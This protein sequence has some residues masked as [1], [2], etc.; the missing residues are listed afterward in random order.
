[1]GGR[2]EVMTSLRVYYKPKEYPEGEEY[3]S[4]SP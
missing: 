1:M 2:H 4:E 3:G